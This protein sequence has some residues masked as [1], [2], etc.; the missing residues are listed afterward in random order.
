MPSIRQLRPGITVMR[1][2]HGVVASSEHDPDQAPRLLAIMV[3]G[4]RAMPGDVVPG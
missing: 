1:L 3:D 2:A 4:L